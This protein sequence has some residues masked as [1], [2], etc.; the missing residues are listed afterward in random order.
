MKC[1]FD[2]R[3]SH[4]WAECINERNER[5]RGNRHFCRGNWHV[6]A[7]CW[8]SWHLLDRKRTLFCHFVE[9]IDMLL[10]KR[11]LCWGSG[12]C[13]E[14]TD[15]VLRKQTLC[16]GNGHCVEETDTVLRKQTLLLRKR[17]FCWG[18]AHVVEEAHMLL[19]KHTFC[20]GNGHFVPNTGRNNIR[21]LSCRHIAGQLLHITHNLS[22]DGGSTLNWGSE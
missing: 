2:I 14:E 3:K 4:D 12:H 9:E 19:R 20:W 7:F 10:R 21:S 22:L 13:D 11:T 6:L 18:N 1:Y 8:G 5:M 15:I 17:I 16:W